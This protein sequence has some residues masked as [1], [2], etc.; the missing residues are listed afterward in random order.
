MGTVFLDN[1]LAKTAKVEKEVLDCRGK[2]VDMYLFTEI[3][4][5]TASLFSKKGKATTIRPFHST[6]LGVLCVKKNPR[7]ALGGVD[8]SDC[9]RFTPAAT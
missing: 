7:D 3:F 6:F 4:E 8:T 1:T 5:R 9:Y 2:V